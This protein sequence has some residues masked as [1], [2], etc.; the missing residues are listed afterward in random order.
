[1]KNVKCIILG[2]GQGKRLFPL[3]RDRSKPAVPI[4]SK[5]R[6]IDIPMSNSLNSGIKQVYILTQFNSV[7]LNNHIHQTYKFDYFSDT[8]VRLLAAEQTIANTKWFQ[9]TA[10]AVRQHIVHYNLQPDSDVLILSGDHLY[11]MDYKKLVDFHRE[12]NADLT[13][14]V[15]AVP[16]KHTPGF[17]IMSLDTNQKIVNFKEKPKEDSELASVQLDPSLVTRF[18]LVPNPPKFLASMGV[19][20][21]K[22]SVLERLLSGTESDFGK[23]LIPKALF[24]YKAY[25]YF[26][27]DYWRDIGTIH[28]YYEASMEMTGPIPPFSFFSE[29]KVF[30]HPRFL[31]PSAVMESQLDQVLIPEGCRIHQAKIKRTIVGLRSVI[32]KGACVEN[33]VLMGADYYEWKV[34]NGFPPIGIGEGSKINRAIIDKNARIGK[35][36]IIENSKRVENFDS[37]NYC[38][39]DGIVIIPKN[40]VIPDGAVI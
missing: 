32:Q 29:E 28:S 38:I 21:F 34:P 31:P 7:S 16:K 12:K 3:T 14:S 24:N 19:Y 36:V 33:T 37:L 5:Y 11:R 8:R 27:N 39:R 22:A 10:D 2:G 17:G 25:G 35:N 26:F 13:I 15:V 6:L 30:T 4:G 40:G 20:V 23:E 9:G 18:G 1:M